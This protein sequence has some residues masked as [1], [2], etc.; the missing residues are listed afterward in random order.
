MGRKPVDVDAYIRAAPKEIQGKLREVRGAIRE[1]APLA[2]E[3]ISYGM[4]Y[5]AYHGR[6]AWF[7]IHTGHIGLYLRPPIVEEYRK[8]LKGYV[9]TKSAVHLPLDRK[10]PVRLIKKMVRARI[11]MNESEKRK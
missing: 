1:A 5:Y 7:G 10:I 11:K 2:H 4:A 6:L 8:D 9:T 3:S